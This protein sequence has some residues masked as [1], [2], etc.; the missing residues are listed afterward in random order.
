MSLIEWFRTKFIPNCSDKTIA[1]LIFLYN[2]SGDELVTNEE[3]KQFVV[4]LKEQ[5][6]KPMEGLDE[7]KIENE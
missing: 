7:V 4:E 5:Y 6:S 3:S 1:A 2:K